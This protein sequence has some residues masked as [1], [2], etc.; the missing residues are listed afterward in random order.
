M[1]M[2]R[3][4][5]SKDKRVSETGPTASADRIPGFDSSQHRQLFRRTSHASLHHHLHIGHHCSV[6]AHRFGS[7]RYLS[8]GQ[9]YFIARHP[10]PS[11]GKRLFN[12]HHTRSIL[13]D[14]PL[15]LTSLHGIFLSGHQ[16]KFTNLSIRL[17]PSPSNSFSLIIPSF[18]TP[19][20]FHHP[21]SI[22]SFSTPIPTQIFHLQ[23]EHQKHPQIFT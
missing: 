9:Q 17:V 23:F 2:P 19:K 4:S 11:S 14:L 10:V 5:N 3:I 6:T 7:G 15:N 18:Q 8:S 21:I 22:D 1:Q 12:Q 16:S 20:S 13:L